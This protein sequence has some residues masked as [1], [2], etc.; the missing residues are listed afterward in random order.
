MIGVS[1]P[2]RGQN[3]IHIQEPAH[4]QGQSSNIRRTFSAVMGGASE[5]ASS[6]VSPSR[7]TIRDFPGGEAAGCRRAPRNR[8]NSSCSSGGNV[9]VAARI[10]A[11][12]LMFELYPWSRERS[13]RRPFWQVRPRLH[14]E[15]CGVDVL[16]HK[17]RALVTCHVKHFSRKAM[18]LFYPHETIRFHD[19]FA[20]GNF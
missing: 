3:E 11:S 2:S 12:A 4:G 6:S 20:S 10:L 1:R 7:R 5:G 18:L 16:S 14:E 8:Y 19:H 17:C 15:D 13:I 9:S